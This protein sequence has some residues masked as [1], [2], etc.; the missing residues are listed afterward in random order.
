MIVHFFIFTILIL[1]SHPKDAKRASNLSL[2]FRPTSF[3][4]HPY[5][6]LVITYEKFPNP[7]TI[8]EGTITTPLHIIS[9]AQCY[10]DGLK[11]VVINGDILDN[12][13]QVL[14]AKKWIVHENFEYRYFESL[15]DLAIIVMS[16]PLTFNYHVQKQSPSFQVFLDAP[17][18]IE[19]ECIGVGWKMFK[20]G[21]IHLHSD[22]ISF[23]SFKHDYRGLYQMA[24][25]MITNFECQAAVDEVAN[26]D[27]E[28]QSS[29]LCGYFYHNDLRRKLLGNMDCF[30]HHGGPLICNIQGTWVFHGVVSRNSNCKNKT[31]PTLF[32]KIEYF[33]DW[34]ISNTVGFPFDWRSLVW[35]K[36]KLCNG[37][38]YVYGLFCGKGINITCVQ[39]NETLFGVYDAKSP[40]LN[41]SKHVIVILLIFLEINFLNTFSY[42]I[43]FWCLSK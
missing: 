37:K 23:K 21:E 20:L 29:M 25:T 42:I 6:A 15:N 26:K 35:C 12:R 1:Y 7:V 16:Q 28:I 2:T 30:G 22:Y 39:P 10:V 43:L 11:T 31:L 27:T 13:S 5:V 3:Y 40:A 18:Y 14:Y 8:C 41:Y 17:P 24:Y 33:K 34:I 36:K 32:T 38:Y 9:S 19:L 4:E